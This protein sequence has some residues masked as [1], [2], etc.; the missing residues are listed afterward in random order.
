MA[1]YEFKLEGAEALVATLEAVETFANDNTS[2]M[3]QVGT[4]MQDQVGRTFSAQSDPI[5]GMPWE[6]TGTLTLSTRPGGGTGG[7]TLWD[8]GALLQSLTASLP[9]TT[10]TTASIWTNL[11]YA[12]TH[13]EGKTI[14]P[15]MKKFLTIPLTRDARRAESAAD[16]ERRKSTKLFVMKPGNGKA[17]LAEDN[18]RRIILHYILLKSVTIPRRRFLGIGDEYGQEIVD[19]INMQLGLAMD[20]N[21]EGRGNA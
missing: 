18:G 13:Q 12:I 8:S 1:D 20:G 4:L 21:A 7:K 14:T 15:K 2:L 10:P 16:L 17:F 3:L 5:T 9:V 19:L 11:P 6:S